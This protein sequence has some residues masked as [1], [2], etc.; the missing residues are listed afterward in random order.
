PKSLPGICLLHRAR[1]PRLISSSLRGRIFH[2]SIAKTARLRRRPP[3]EENSCKWGDSCTILPESV[4]A[5]TKRAGHDVCQQKTE[6]P[7][8]YSSSNVEN[9][10]AEPS[11]GSA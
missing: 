1:C 9:G 3:W 10:C 2:A 7:T 5:G 8:R 6:S 4:R 11:K